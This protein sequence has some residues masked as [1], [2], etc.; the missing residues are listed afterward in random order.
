MFRFRFLAHVVKLIHI[1]TNGNTRL[2]AFLYILFVGLLLD[3][4][5]YAP[6]TSIIFIPL[7]QL[8]IDKRL[9]KHK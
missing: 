7:M 6:S 4:S 8:T 1:L 3:F 9:I 5:F 2:I